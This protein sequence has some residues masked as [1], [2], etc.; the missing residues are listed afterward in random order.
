M[1]PVEKNYD[2]AYEQQEEITPN[3]TEEDFLLWLNLFVLG[4]RML[5]EHVGN[6]DPITHI[7]LCPSY[8]GNLGREKVACYI[9]ELDSMAV[10][11]KFVEA[12]LIAIKKYLTK[13]NFRITNVHLNRLGV[14]TTPN[15][16]PLFTG[17]EERAHAYFHKH[18]KP[19]LDHKEINFTGRYDGSDSSEEYAFQQIASIILRNKNLSLDPLPED[20]AEELA[21]SI[22]E[23]ANQSVTR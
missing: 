19:N 16:M 21:I 23:K 2:S 4:Q 20:F 11:F 7:H 18:V 14:C 5:D 17:I 13:P 3:F 10:S 8:K 12:D 22:K 1:L 6:A 9:E 15:L